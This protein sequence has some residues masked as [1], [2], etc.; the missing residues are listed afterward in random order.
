MGAYVHAGVLY[1]LAHSLIPHATIS[2]DARRV[3]ATGMM[4][5]DSTELLKL[6]C[7]V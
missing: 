1:A 5:C 4:N 6:V 7:M 2:L 3:A